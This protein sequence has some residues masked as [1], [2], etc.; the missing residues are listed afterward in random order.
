[1]EQIK[2]AV[3]GAGHL[4]SVHARV[5]NQL[6]QAELVGVYDIDRARAEQVAGRLG[7]RSFESL[8]HLADSVR[9]VSLAVPTDLHY[10]LGKFMLERGIHLLVEKPVTER[11]DQAAELIGLAREKGVVLQ[12]GHVERF[13]PALIAASD[14]ISGSLFIDSLRLAPFNVRGTEV[15]VV[16]D[17]MIHDIDI[18]LS[19]VGSPVVEV[20]A[21]GLPVMTGKVDIASARLGFETG[22]VANVVASRVSMKRERKMRFFAPD[23]YVS[24]DLLGRAG[25]SY[26]KRAGVDYSEIAAQASSLAPAM[27][28]LVGRRKLEVD[29]K[30]EPLALEIED[31]LACISIGRRPVVDGADGLRALEV[32]GRIMTAI[33]SS[34][35]RAGLEDSAGAQ[36]GEE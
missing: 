28:R 7:V 1:M 21:S 15:P 10:S 22:A 11:A 5:Y 31:F 6:K 32:A 33:D 2:V 26:R 27:S 25:V 30:A 4:G 34:L 24:V 20:S 19:I 36:G 18:I 12:V 35:A 9:A 23:C 13:N 29:K 16:L 3:A 17:L 8:E 14:Y